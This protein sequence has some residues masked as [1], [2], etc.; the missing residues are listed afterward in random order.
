[1]P[2][3]PAPDSPSRA[4]L[5]ARLVALRAST[6]LSGNAFAKR[7]GVAQSHRELPPDDIRRWTQSR[8]WKI[9]HRALPPTEEDIRTWVAAAGEPEEVA[10]ELIDL[11]DKS[12]P[13]YESWRAAYGRAGGAAALEQLYREAEERTTLIGEFQIAFIPGLLQTRQYA[14]EIVTMRCGPLKWDASE[15]DIEAKVNERMQRTEIIYDSTKRIQ[16]VLGE[17][18]LRTRMTSPATLIDQL[19]KL[20]MVAGL[21][22]VELGIIGFDQH[23]PIYALSGFAILDDWAQ[24]EHLGGVQDLTEPDDVAF[25]TDCFNQAREAAST[26]P[27][28]IELIERAIRDLSQGE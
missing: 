22:T 14:R 2:A 10:R 20:E 6:G 8:V 27:A 11:L 15:A 12:R 26:G 7:L 25:W 18:S 13:E 1:L 21:P 5:V 19:H 3:P 28:A 9:E 4:T 17:A 23:M 16:V 24:V